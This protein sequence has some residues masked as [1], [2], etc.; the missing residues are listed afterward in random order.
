MGS[1]AASASAWALVN[2]RIRA[3]FSANSELIMMTFPD[4][5]LILFTEI[6]ALG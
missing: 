5:T 2:M 3:A 6:P 4:A 1:N